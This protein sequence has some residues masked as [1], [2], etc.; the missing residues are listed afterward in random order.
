MRDAMEG[1]KSWLPLLGRL[2]K[3]TGAGPI[4]YVCSFRVPPTYLLPSDFPLKKY[5]GLCFCQITSES[6]GDC[7]LSTYWQDEAHYRAHGCS[8]RADAGVPSPES[9]GMLTRLYAPSEFILKR[10]DLKDWIIIISGLLATLALMHTWLAV[11]IDSPDA[12]VAF[13][14]ATPLDTGSRGAINLPVN[15]IN[16][17][18]FAPMRISKIEAEAKPR[19]GGASISL[20]PDLPNLPS[21][22]PGQTTQI[23]INGIAPQKALG[24]PRE[25]YEVYVTMFVHIG[26]LRGQ[27]RA[28]PSSP[29]TIFVW[30]AEIGWSAPEIKETGGDY[31]R[32]IVYLYPGRKFPNGARGS[33]LV[34]GGRDEV[35]SVSATGQTQELPPSLPDR[36]GAVT[37]VVKFQTSVLERFERFALEIRLDACKALTQDRWSQLAKEI[38]VSAK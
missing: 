31:C 5:P 7:T 2:R 37:R 35:T 38:R 16:A 24:S 22:A 1:R 34:V 32:L 21:V 6:I 11:M 27:G 14:D 4:P 23:K 18:A 12:T 25:E 30:P 29:R 9:E 20:H 28:S 3:L 26:M 17:S 15:A 19:N 8:F 33:V 13:T 10:F 36:R